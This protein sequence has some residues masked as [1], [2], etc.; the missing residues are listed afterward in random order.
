[1][2]SFSTVNKSPRVYP[3]SPKPLS[4][5]QAKPTEENHHRDRTQNPAPETAH[6]PQTD[7]QND[8]LRQSTCPPR[9]PL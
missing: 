3:H 7:H 6:T 8:T 1:M 5:G 4:T 9:P 2:G